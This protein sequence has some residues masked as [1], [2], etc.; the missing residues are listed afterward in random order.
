MRWRDIEEIVHALEENYS[1][2]D[3]HH[4]KLPEVEEMVRSLRDFED[5]ETNA[6]KETLNKILE[7]WIELREEG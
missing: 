5:Q 7:A 3:V 1:D 4:L 6:S 2:E